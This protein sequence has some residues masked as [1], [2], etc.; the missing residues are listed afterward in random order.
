MKKGSYPI[1]KGWEMVCPIPKELVVIRLDNKYFFE[2]SN[3]RGHEE[4][5]GFQYGLYNHDSIYYIIRKEIK[6]I[7]LDN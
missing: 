7:D 6:T 1:D 5:Q 4:Y 2:F 3:Q